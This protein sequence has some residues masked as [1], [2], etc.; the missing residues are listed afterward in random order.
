VYRFGVISHCHNQHQ[1]KPAHQ[2][3]ERTALF[4]VAPLLLIR[5]IKFLFAASP[6]SKAGAPP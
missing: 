1:N 4:P 5:N 6:Q 3:D 2:P